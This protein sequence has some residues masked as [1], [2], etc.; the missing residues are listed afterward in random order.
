M[1]ANDPCSY[2][3]GMAC[4]ISAHH[5]LPMVFLCACASTPAKVHPAPA[6]AQT[7]GQ[8]QAAPADAPPPKNQCH[9]TKALY[10]RYRHPHMAELN[11]CYDQV[12]LS[13]QNASITLRVKVT[14]NGWG[15]VDNASVLSASMHLPTFEQCV[16][17]SVRNWVFCAPI[18]GSVIVE[19]T[20]IFEE[21]T[22]TR[23]AP[24]GIPQV[25]PASNTAH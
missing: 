1:L 20:F 17:S 19:D 24:Q 3:A 2:N 7:C 12:A 18:G 23:E 8:P 14:V 13:P 5:V 15:T 11:A 25:F 22:S 6:A 4:R 16:L 10:K 9:W 21:P